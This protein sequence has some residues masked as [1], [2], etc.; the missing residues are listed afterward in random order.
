MRKYLLIFVLICST[1]CLLTGC[2]SRKELNEISVVLA[3]GIDYVDGSFEVTSQVVDPS[4][5]SSMKSTNRSP[6]IVVTERGKTILEAIRRVTTKSPRKLYGA[7]LGMVIISENIARQG[8]NEALDMLLRDPEIR[9]DLYV[10]IARGTSP[11]ELLA[12]MTPFEVL[13]GIEMYNAL[14]VSQDA[15]APTS[16]DTIVEIFQ[17]ELTEG[18]EP[19]ITGISLIGD[20]IKGKTPQNI[21]RPE[22]AAEY[23]YQGLGVFRGD[24]LVGWLNESDSKAY[25]YIMN[26][27]KNT[28]GSSMC[29]NEKGRFA[30]EVYSSKAKIIPKLVGN[31][32]NILI[33]LRIEGNIAESSCNMD[34]GSVKQFDALQKAGEQQL[35]AIIETGVKQVQKK[36]RVDIFGFGAA[37]HRAYPKEWR[38]WSKDWNN[39][40]RKLPIEIKLDFKLKQTGKIVN[41]MKPVPNGE[42]EK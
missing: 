33:D 32:V 14:K 23:K 41:N 5:M 31:E 3:V 39:H 26:D 34:L 8:M 42:E 28:V 1:S 27:V 16:A 35:R 36:M 25:S 40:F 37:I 12:L 24:M 15:W 13:S 19:V 22:P 30:V 11:K 21:D 20:K 17:K 29:P 18:I 9:P 10:T 2:W 38:V 4:Q 6:T 7:H